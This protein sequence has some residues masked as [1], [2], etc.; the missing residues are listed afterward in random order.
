MTKTKRIVF[1]L[2]AVFL[3]AGLFFLAQS[4]SPKIDLLQSQFPGLTSGNRV[5][6]PPQN[7]EEIRYVYFARDGA[8]RTLTQIEYRSGITSLTV[9]RTD[10]VARETRLFYPLKEGAGKRQLRSLVTFQ[11]DG[12]S[13]KSHQVYREDGSLE[14]NGGRLSDGEYQTLYFNSKDGSVQRRL[15]YS[16][17][18]QLENEESYSDE[19]K[20]VEKTEKLNEH[21]LKTT[22]WTVDGK[23]LSEIT[24]V[25]DGRRS[26]KLYHEDGKTVRIEFD[27]LGYQ[28]D[29]KYFDKDGKASY[30]VEHVPQGKSITVYGGDEKQRYKQYWLL[31]GGTTLCDATYRLIRVE[32]FREDSPSDLLRVIGVSA[33]GKPNR[34]ITPVDMH[35]SVERTDTELYPDGS[36]KSEKVIDDNDNVTSDKSFNQGEQKF[37]LKPE[38]FGKPVIECLDPPDSKYKVILNEDEHAED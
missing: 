32:E 21:S 2:L 3:T 38:L 7:G 19:G 28:I 34:V 18:G 17:S 12:T 14:R 13:Y 31:T 4:G 5:E 6:L 9:Y 37:D 26:G 1:V 30:E 35:R 25:E 20:L 23:L 24:D 15:V 10:G 29:V 36:V 27:H 11:D 8:T 33:D 16:A 22:R